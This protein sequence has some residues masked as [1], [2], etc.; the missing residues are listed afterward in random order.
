MTAA[1]KA[2]SGGHPAPLSADASIPSHTLCRT[3]PSAIAAHSSVDR[4]RIGAP[5]VR[6]GGDDEVHPRRL[7]VIGTPDEHHRRRPV[8][9]ELGDRARTSGRSR[10]VITTHSAEAVSSSSSARSTE[11]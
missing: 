5:P 4:E 6:V 10:A 8:L 9:P 3:A 11:P 1:A 2:A 7:V